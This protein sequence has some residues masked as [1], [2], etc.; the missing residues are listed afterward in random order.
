MIVAS[1]ISISAAVIKKLILDYPSQMIVW[2]QSAFVFHQLELILKIL[3]KKYSGIKHS[4][5]NLLGSI[6]YAFVYCARIHKDID[7]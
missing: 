2:D 1:D 4:I 6:S 5:I 3:S 7:E